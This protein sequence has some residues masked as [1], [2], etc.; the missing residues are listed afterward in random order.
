MQ[1]TKEDRRKLTAR[2]PIFTRRIHVD[3]KAW[4]DRHSRAEACTSL[5][6]HHRIQ[7]TSSINTPQF[8][9]KFVHELSA[10]EKVFFRRL[11]FQKT[12]KNLKPR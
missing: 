1:I 12:R 11:R 5:T 10:F 9:R 7:L 8:N 3:S 2:L 4:A 6:L